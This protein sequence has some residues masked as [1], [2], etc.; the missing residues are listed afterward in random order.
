[1]E[2]QAVPS[3]FRLL[4]GG[5]TSENARTR[6]SGRLRAPRRRTSPTEYTASTETLLFESLTR[7]PH[8]APRGG[9]QPEG[10]AVRDDDE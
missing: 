7:K 6:G 8:C 2:K 3:L 5:K 4:G 1:M 10:H 9:E